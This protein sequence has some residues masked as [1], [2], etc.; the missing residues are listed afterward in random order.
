MRG[1]RAHLNRRAGH[2][3]AA[4]ALNALDGD[5]RLNGGVFEPVALVA[6]HEPDVAQLLEL[7]DENFE[8]VVRDDEQLAAVLKLGQL[9]LGLFVVGA[10]HLHREV[11][12]EPLLKLLAPV[13]DQRARRHDQ[14]LFG[15]RL[16]ARALS[17]QR[18]HQ[19]NALQRFALRARIW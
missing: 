9:R 15:K 11:V 17:Q 19:R 8:L 14:H 16:A 13:L 18:V 3:N 2:D 7:V 10:D 1:R 4:L 6:D 12:A 5:R